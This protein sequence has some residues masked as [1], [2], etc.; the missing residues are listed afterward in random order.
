[1]P[2]PPG[3]GPGYEVKRQEIIDQAAALF[4]KQGYAATGIAELG[5][6]A[7]LAKGAL[8]YYIGSKENLLVEIQDRVLGPL[9][10]GAR[11]IAALDE[12]P[13]LKLR[14]LSQALL[15]I[16]L[17]R[18]D[19]IW[20]Y[21]HDYRHLTG[22]NRSRLLRQRRE[23]EKIVRGLLVAAM[24][25]GAFRRLDPRLAMLQFLNLHNHTYQWAR[26]D[27]PWDAAFLSREY[28]ATLISGFCSDGYDVAGLEKRLAEY[29]E[30]SSA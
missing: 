22:S 8:Y 14:L 3:H 18:L 25:V 4:A 6:V 11:S 17:A 21:E 24:D 1:M 27:G 13:V 23:F 12:D 19:H 5:E 30:R 15:D 20:V 16:I 28:C 9:L 7:G 10:T 29:R 26:A 2:R